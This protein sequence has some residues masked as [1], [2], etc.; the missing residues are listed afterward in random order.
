VVLTDSQKKKISDRALGDAISQNMNIHDQIAAIR[1][2]IIVIS[3]A[4]NV[5]LVQELAYLEQLVLDEKAKKPNTRGVKLSKQ[6]D[7]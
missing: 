3:T 5:P 7:L 1:K 6:I 4:A 2:Q